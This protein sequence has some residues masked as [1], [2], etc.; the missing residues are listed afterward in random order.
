MMDEKTYTISELNESIRYTLQARFSPYIWVQG[1][2]MGWDRG[3]HKQHIYFELCEK[4]EESDNILARISC[5]MFQ[6][7]VLNIF[8]KLS[9]CENPFNLEDGLHIRFK[10]K[11]DFYPAWGKCQLIVIDIDPV[12]T[13]GKLFQTRQK[14]LDDLKKR[15]LLD[16]NKK[17]EIP[18]VPLKIGLITSYNSAAYNDFISSLEKS[19]YA[20]NVTLYNAVMQGKDTERTL[21]RGIDYFNEMDDIDVLVIIRGGGAKTDLIWFD[22]KNI[23]EKIANSKYP[24]LTGIGHEIDLSVADMVAH[25]YFKTPTAVAEFLVS[26]VDDYIKDVHTL[27]EEIK[28]KT[29]EIILDEKDYLK[30]TKQKFCDVSK[31]IFRDLYYE[32]NTFINKLSPKKILKDIGL[33]KDEILKYV[34]NLEEAIN[35]YFKNNKKDIEILQ[36]RI[37][38]VDPQ[39]IL[40]RGFSFI[41]NSKNKII[42]S[43]DEVGVGEKVNINL[44][45]GVLNSKIL[46]K[47]KGEKLL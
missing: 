21:C 41:V 22:N 17:I 42:K 1:E 40:K 25:S 6:E 3:K 33:K 5:V 34:K 30:I 26:K 39:N 31:Y 20:W 7:S 47:V 43:V 36:E 15:G 4:E 10:C 35:R 8:E 9:L 19:G 2:L 29:I 32:I 18:D 38:Y 27:F 45:D 24:V 11:V 37:K 12:W 16:K 44:S 28:E 13:L 14:L 46:S 23:A